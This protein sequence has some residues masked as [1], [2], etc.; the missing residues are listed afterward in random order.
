MSAAS[1]TDALQIRMPEL[2]IGCYLLAVAFDE[3]NITTALDAGPAD[4]RNVFN[5]GVET[6]VFFEV[7]L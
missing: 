2:Q 3:A 7:V 5:L 4:L 6:Q 1:D